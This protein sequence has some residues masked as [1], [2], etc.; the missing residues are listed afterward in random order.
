M[1]ERPPPG[2]PGQDRPL[3]HSFSYQFALHCNDEAANKFQATFLRT[4]SIEVAPDTIEVNPKHANFGEDTGP[5][6]LSGSRVQFITIS[7]MMKLTEAAVNTDK[8]NALNVYS[9]NIHGAFANTWTPADDNTTTTIAQL[10]H[11]TST[12]AQ[13]DVVPEVTGVNINPDLA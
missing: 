5:L 1:P 12:A 7:V 3:P 8:I 10:L 4:S 2:Y 11:V 6:I 9:W 13:E